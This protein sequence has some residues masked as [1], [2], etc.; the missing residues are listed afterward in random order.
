MKTE[1][2]GVEDLR[3]TVIALPPLARDEDGALSRAQNQRLL[4]HVASGGVR[5]VAYAANANLYHI[6]RTDYA[7]MLEML[8]EITDESM[9]AIPGVGPDFGALTD[10]AEMLRGTDFPAAHLLPSHGPGTETGLL[11]GIRRF[12]E[13]AEKPV[14][15]EWNREDSMPVDGVR[16]LLE[17]GMVAWIQYGIRRDQPA[18][19]ALLSEIVRVAGPGRVVSGLGERAAVVHL[20]DFGMPTFASGAA[21]IAPAL[22]QRM[23]DRIRRGGV[24]EAEEIRGVFRKF[25]ILREKAGAVAVLH[26]GVSF[27]GIAHTGPVLPFLSEVEDDY[28]SRV[29]EAA[30]TLLGENG[31]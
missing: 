27:A 11:R 16:G 15:L 8:G 17:D 20:R 1:L 7:A 2:P 23:L 30:Q 24:V 21:A 25:G 18:S 12:V 13:Q 5:V 6:S 3:Q 28:R 4:R 31:G 10:Q 26:E 14:V 29:R 19:D 9:V 22:A